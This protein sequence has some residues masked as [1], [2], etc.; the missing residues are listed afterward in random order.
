MK[1][2]QGKKAEQVVAT[3][4]TERDILGFFYSFD[5]HQ[6]C[7]LH[8]LKTLQVDS[9]AKKCFDPFNK[10]K[11]P[12]T[13]KL[14]LPEVALVKEA[15]QYLPANTIKDLTPLKMLCISC[16]KDMEDQVSEA[17]EQMHSQIDTPG[18]SQQSTN[19]NFSDA[20]SFGRKELSVGTTIEAASMTE[21]NRLR[22][23]EYHLQA[24]VDRLNKIRTE[25]DE[26]LENIKETIPNMDLRGKLSLVSLLPKNWGRRKKQ[27]ELGVSDWLVRKSC[28]LQKSGDMPVRKVRSDKLSEEDTEA[29]NDFF[30]QRHI[31]RELPGAKDYKSVKVDGV[32]KRLRKHLLLYTLEDAYVHFKKENPDVKVGLTKFKELRPPQVVLAGAS[33][34]HNVCVCINHENPNLRITTSVL[35]KDVSFS[36]LLLR[37]NPEATLSAVSLLHEIVC[38]SGDLNCWLGDGDGCEDCDDLLEKLKE[39]LLEHFEG[40]G[41]LEVEF[42]QWLATDFSTSFTLHEPVEIFVVNL[43]RALKELKPHHFL[44]K[45]QEENFKNQL[46]SLPPGHLLIIMDYAENYCFKSQNSVQS[47]YYINKQCTLHPI[48]IYYNEN[49]TVSSKPKC[50]VVISDSLDHSA[51]TVSCFYKRLHEDIIK[52]QFPFCTFIQLWTDGAPTQVKGHSKNSFTE[53]YSISGSIRT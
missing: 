20:S 35:S 2:L 44:S 12:R 45:K 9:K 24:E 22:E 8:K 41:T 3:T 21:L 4:S 18:C 14:K 28:D 38:D 40:L 15:V 32:R 48:V 46:Q 17:K 6:I 26:I 37:K 13:A 51:G 49:G 36:T 47:S 7:A 43:T 39:I 19:S 29:V 5:I 50:C 53:F 11:K 34:T 52:K 1:K 31:S 30:L 33:G 23:R 10:H 16:I 42:D 27:A 25:F